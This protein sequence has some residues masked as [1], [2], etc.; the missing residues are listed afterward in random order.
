MSAADKSFLQKLGLTQKDVAVALE[1]TPQTV[2]AGMGHPRPYFDRR[3]LNLLEAFIV[4]S[5]KI[6][7]DDFLQAKQDYIAREQLEESQK[8]PGKRPAEEADEFDQIWIFTNSSDAIETTGK[9]LEIIGTLSGQKDKVVVLAV[10]SSQSVDLCFQLL[11]HSLAGNETTPQIYLFEMPEADIPLVLQLRDAHTAS[12]KVFTESKD[13]T[14][15]R[16]PDRIGTSYVRLFNEHGFG[17]GQSALY[18]EESMLKSSERLTLR[19]KTDNFVDQ[20][21]TYLL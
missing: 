2:S 10:P 7:R 3:R 8:G 19:Y 14:M 4:K 6:S 18:T 13:G 12:P 20:D 15:T 21:R 9:I 1:C 11:T 5:G 16:L 17:L